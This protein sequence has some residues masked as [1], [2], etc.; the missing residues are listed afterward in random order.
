MERARSSSFKYSA[1]SAAEASSHRENQ[2]TIL[3]QAQV[4]LP[5]I[6]CFV[7][8]AVYFFIDSNFV[9]WEIAPRRGWLQTQS[10]RAS[11]H[12]PE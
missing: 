2:T 6:L 8:G 11:P 5:D 10:F 3:Q 7:L 9:W 4:N 12:C 1:W